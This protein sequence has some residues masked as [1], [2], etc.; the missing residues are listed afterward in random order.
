M[1]KT[2]RNGERPGWLDSLKPDELSRERL[3]RHVLAEAAVILRARRAGNWWSVADR[4]TTRLLPLAAALALVFA[5][6]AQWVSQLPAVAEMPPT[7]DELLRS[8]NPNG[9]PDVLISATEPGLDQLLS[10]AV[11]PDA[12]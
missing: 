5:G 2:D 4:W 9:P 11:T 1:K 8:A 10:A 6:M 3:R 12:P 7:V